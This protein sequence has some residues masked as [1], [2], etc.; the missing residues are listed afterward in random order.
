M[1]TLANLAKSFG[2]RTLFADVS[3]QLNPGERY[4]L[5]GANG[6][7][8]TTLLNILAGDV[9]ASKGEVA[10]AQLGESRVC[11]EAGSEYA[12]SS[13]AYGATQL[14]VH[15]GNALTLSSTAPMATS[16]SSVPTTLVQARRRYDRPARL[17]PSTAGS[18]TAA[19]PRSDAT[20]KVRS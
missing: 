4:G 7:G 20:S 8:K 15:D 17:R 6:S 5:V 1:I 16:V 3:M 12:V 13:T 9:E 10:L 11:L 14:S 18:A 19:R 2:D